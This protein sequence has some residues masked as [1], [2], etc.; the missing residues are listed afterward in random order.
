MRLLLAGVLCL[1]SVTAQVKTKSAFD[2]AA[3][4]TYIRHLLP[5]QEGVEVRIADPKP[6]PMPGLKEVM[7][8]LTYGKFSQDEVFYVS[9][10]GKHILRGNVY[11]VNQNPF[12][13]ELDKLKTDL[14]PSYGT[15][16][17]PV[18]LIEFSDFQCPVCKEEAKV[19][20][21]Q[22]PAAYANQF[23][24]YYKDFPLEPIHPWSKAAAICGR[25]VF[26]QNAAA[27]WDF[28]DW[29]FEHQPEITPENLKTK[30][31]EWAQSKGMDSLQLGRCIDTRAT[32]AEVDR[33]IA[34]GKALGVN[35]TPTIFLNG[36]RLIGVQWQALEQFMNIELK[37]QKTA[38][39]AGEKCCEVKVPIPSSTGAAGTGKP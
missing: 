5:I 6:G 37:Y 19:L 38:Q 23:R 1:L 14:A 2:K 7:A 25:C 31:L 8:H 4:E 28:H 11:D 29:L 26:R 27:F 30:V 10:D 9:D 32:E 34:E 12:Q 15:P 3:F 18:V 24:V 39:D 22:L 21:Q 16:G 35:A 36:R 13:P 33:E 20:R 17:A